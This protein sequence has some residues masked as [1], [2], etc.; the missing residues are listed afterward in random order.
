MIRQIKNWNNW[1]SAIRAIRV[2]ANPVK[3]FKYVLNPKIETFLTLKTPTGPQHIWCRNQETAKTTYSVFAREDYLTDERHW[4]IIDIGSNVGVTA[5]YFLSRNAQNKIYCVEPDPNNL[6]F[7]EKNIEVFEGRTFLQKVAV[8]PKD[9]GRMTMNLSRDGKYS[10][11]LP[12]KDE[13]S[14]ITEVEVV[15]IN[16]VIEEALSLLDAEN[17]MIKIDIEGME[18][19]VAKAIDFFAFP[20]IKRLIV[21][22]VGIGEHLSKP[23]TY[24]VR[25]GYVEVIDFG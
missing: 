4:D 19:D 1:S 11:L 12:I 10:S 18:H 5:V 25:N 14:T 23:C 24:H 20:R 22:G 21:E 7:L 6:P 17:V 13:G 2:F 15:P 8:A 9:V 3:F 16:T